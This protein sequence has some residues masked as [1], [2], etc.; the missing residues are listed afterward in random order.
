VDTGRFASGS[1][2]TRQGEIKLRIRFSMERAEFKLERDRQMNA[3]R[4]HTITLSLEG[5]PQDEKHVRLDDFMAQLRSLQDALTCIDH[6][7]NGRT[8][9]YYRIVDLRHSSP[10]TVQIEPVLRETFRKGGFRNK[11]R[12]SPEI[13]HHRFFESLESIRFQGKKIENTREETVDAFMELINGLGKAFSTGSIFNNSANVPLD[14]GLSDSLESLMKPGFV[15]HG[16]VM[17]HLLSISFARGNRFYLYPQV[18]PTSIACHFDDALE[19]KARACIKRQ[20]RV[21]GQ[22]YFRPNTGLPFRVDVSKIEEL[23]LPRKFI[24]IAGQKPFL[25]EPAHESIAKARDEWD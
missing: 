22:K 24:Q 21:F 8:T 10:A 16:S 15:S 13:V 23:R 14:V 20:V 19:K 17:G 12:N 7:A 11:Y 9:L 6:E 2:Q 4:E 18:G 25:G 1:Q 3:P 5:T